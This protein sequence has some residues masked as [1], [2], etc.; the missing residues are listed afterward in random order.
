M[1]EP[2]VSVVVCTR[3]RATE[4]RQALDY[5]TRISAAIPWELILVDNGSTD[6]TQDVIQQ[7][8]STT[9]IAC[10]SVLEPR[11]GLSR[12]R[13]RG[14][15]AARA[16]VIAFTDDDCYPQP[17]Y[18]SEL[19]AGFGQPAIG[20]LGGQV[21]LYDPQDYPITIQTRAQRLDIPPRSFVRAGLVHGANMAARRTVLE[22]VGGFDEMLGAGT[23]FP[24]ED[25][26][27][28]SRASA[29]G[30][31]GA[32][33]PRP[34]VRHHHERRESAE[35]RQLQRAYDLGRGAYYAKGF[36]DPARRRNIARGWLAIFRE[37]RRYPH[38]VWGP[39]PTTFFELTGA[40]CYLGQLLSRR[41][42]RA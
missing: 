41:F 39:G 40:L 26:D 29:A 2:C 25:V 31:G 42:T 13:N 15:R 27:F 16:P 12:A 6:A 36:L 28:L 17:D 32:Y 10:R 34:V 7:F 23:P 8:A 5:W 18:V 9:D 19:W 33:D 38:Q 3:N 1:P 35:I 21:L 22:A 37:Q 14:W 20:Y 24:A 11:P 30:F 4:L